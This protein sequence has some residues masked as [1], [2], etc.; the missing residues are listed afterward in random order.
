MTRLRMARARLARQVIMSTPHRLWHWT[1]DPIRH[2]IVGAYLW[3][4]TAPNRPR[5]P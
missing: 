3:P 1:P 5:T 2:H 4:Y